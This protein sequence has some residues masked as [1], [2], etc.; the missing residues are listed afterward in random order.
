M[1]L[2]QGCNARVIPGDGRADF[3][4]WTSRS[5][6]SSGHTWV[7]RSVHGIRGAIVV[8][9]EIDGG[10]P[11]REL[12]CSAHAYP[13]RHDFKALAAAD[14]TDDSAAAGGDAVPADDISVAFGVDATPSVG[15]LSLGTFCLLFA[16][17]IDAGAWAQLLRNIDFFRHL[18]ATTVFTASPRTFAA[19]N[20]SGVF[21]ICH[22]ELLIVRDTPFEFEAVE[23]MVPYHRAASGKWIF[24]NDEMLSRRHVLSPVR[25]RFVRFLV[26]D[27]GSWTAETDWTRSKPA[28]PG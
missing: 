5:D 15:F 3:V 18:A 12:P 24:E 22:P 1:S 28:N 11:Q 27:D 25:D 2:E 7:A 9:G 4:S 16:N 6:V 26:D 23:S 8:H 14:D 20:R 17:S 10:T 19:A 13:S 21:N